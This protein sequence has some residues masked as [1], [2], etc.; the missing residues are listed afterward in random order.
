M[1]K[2]IMALG[3][4]AAVALALVVGP[5]SARTL[6]PVRLAAP[7]TD[8]IDNAVIFTAQDRGYF[9]ANGVAVE[10]TLFRGAGAA[11]EALAAGAAD[12]T[13]IVAP[14]AAI[15]VAKGIHEKIVGIGPIVSND[16][17]VLMVR[18]DSPLKS[19]ADLAD[20]RVG[21]SSKNSTTDFYAT[22]VGEKY[23]V[24][25]LSVP[26][27]GGGIGALSAKQI[28]AMV[29]APIL[30]YKLL[31]GHSAYRALIDF[32]KSKDPFLPGTFAAASGFLAKHGTAV[33]GF[34]KA[35]Y[36]AAAYLGAHKAYAIKVLEKFTHEKDPA[37][38]ETEFKHV[39]LKLGTTGKASAAD[40]E[41]SIRF[42]TLAGIANVPSLS[43]LV[44]P[45]AIAQ[46]R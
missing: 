8:D 39:I 42:A 10:T 9:A 22:W 3:L 1:A 32:G 38:L 14:G 41:S 12:V 23:H 40:L 21:I 29:V 46:A 6:T 37:L 11:Q 30:A 17:W 18:A 20:K 25:F 27:G 4:S 28:D 33:R 2:R 35:D 36:R 45:Y 31:S 43:T 13:V 5:A 26:I 19:P 16:G 15:A 7:S 34:L 24:S 44:A